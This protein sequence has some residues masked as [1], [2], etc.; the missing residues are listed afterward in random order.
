MIE[1]CLT[2]G[3]DLLCLSS[4]LLGNCC[5]K[6]ESHNL[7]LFKTPEGGDGPTAYCGCN[8]IFSVGSY[9][10]TITAVDGYADWR[11]DGGDWA[12]TVY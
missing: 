8:R 12:G 4:L 1:V 3:L 10:A 7:Y 11:I 6:L 5:V 2:S 9:P